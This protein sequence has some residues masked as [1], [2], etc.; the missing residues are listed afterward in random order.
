MEQ[1]KPLQAFDFPM[2]WTATL[3]LRY[4]PD[5]HGDILKTDASC[6]RTAS[7]SIGPVASATNDLATLYEIEIEAGRMLKF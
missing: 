4:L 3:P 5:A 2:H 7:A 6:S 1:S